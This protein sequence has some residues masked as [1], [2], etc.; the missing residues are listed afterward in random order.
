M[1]MMES[2]A[3]TGSAEEYSIAEEEIAVPAGIDERQV[4]SVE[5]DSTPLRRWPAAIAELY[6]EEIVQ[7]IYREEHFLFLLGLLM[8][9]ATIAVDM[10]VNPDMAKEG[11][12]L[13]VLVVAPLTLIGLIAGARGWSQVLA[14]CVGASP[15]A[16]IAVVVHLAVHLP[17]DLAPRYIHATILLVGL[18]NVILPYSLR[19]L[20]I[21]DVSAILVTAAMLFLGG[22]DILAEHADTLVILVLV[23]A[24]TLPVA[25]RFEKLRQRN[26]LLT[27]RARIF[28]RELLKA[29]RALHVLSQSD[30]LTGI[31]NRRGFESHFETAIV[32]PGEN[33]RG[34][35]LVALMM[36]DLDFFKAF[37]DA[38][39]HQAGD[40]C[41]KLVA[42]ALIDIFDSADGIVGRYGGEEFVAALRT[43]DRAVILA[44]AEEVRRTIATVLT[45]VDETDRSLVTASIGVAIAPA[46]AM[47]PREELLEMADA[48]LYSGK[49][50]GRN[51]V[52]VVEAE[53][54]F[55]IRP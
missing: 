21:F 13:R 41:L 15:I 29:N 40:S 35:D 8:C 52:E 26:F 48:A 17:P 46:S 24:A 12:V 44:V 55:G 4:E 38:H 5:R 20:V 14:F 51:R 28:S 34:T 10:I 32:A 36:I 45:P 3:P 31:A 54:A 19:G 47:L 30:P 1:G 6:Y 42:N 43:R 7:R 33:G 37:N 27:L 18:A 23:A 2:F 49:D 22:P 53:V 11:A 25:A 9:L 16:F 39:G 50:R